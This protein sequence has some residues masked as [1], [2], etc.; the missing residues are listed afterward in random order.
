MF[1]PNI[2]NTL[3]K[4]SY[5]TRSSSR[6]FCEKLCSLDASLKNEKDI[7]GVIT[8]Q[9]WFFSAWKQDPTIKSMLCMLSGTDNSDD[10]NG[11]FVDGIEELFAN[12]TDFG[13]Y[14]ECLKSADCPIHFNFLPLSSDE[15]PVSDDLY[16]KMNARGK[17]LSSFENFKA[18]LIKWIYKDENKN[19]FGENESERNKTRAEYASLIDNQWTDIFWEAGEEKGNV[20]E[21]YFAFI[22]RFLLNSI[23]IHN[24]FTP[25]FL[26]NG[27]TKTDSNGKEYLVKPEL[28]DYFYGT[29]YEGDTKGNDDRRIAYK[30]FDFYEKALGYGNSDV[31]K[32]LKKVFQLMPERS[33]MAS[34]FPARIDK[35]GKFFIPTYSGKDIEDF[36]HVKIKETTSITLQQRVV[37]EAIC[38]YMIEADKFEETSFRRWMRVVW[39]I[40]E[41]TNESSSI[42]DF[43]TILKLINQLSKGCLDIYK[44][45]QEPEYINSSNP[46]VREEAVKAKQILQKEKEND[47]VGPDETEIIEAENY[48]F[49]NGAIRFLFTSGDGTVC[50][51]DFQTK[52]ERA[53]Q[54]FNDKGLGEARWPET[55]KILLSYCLDWENQLKRKFLFGDSSSNWIPILKSKTFIIPIHN[56]LKHY[57][58]NNKPS[59]YY[60]DILNTLLNND[61]FWTFI[62]TSDCKDKF[63]LEWK[64]N[65][66]SLWLKNYLAS[67][68]RLRQTERDK[69]LDKLSN[70]CED[71]VLHK[72][73]YVNTTQGKYFKCSP[74]NIV[75]TYRGYKFVW[76]DSDWVDMYEGETKCWD[77]AENTEYAKYYKR[78]HTHFQIEIEHGLSFYNGETLIKELERCITE[79]KI[80]KNE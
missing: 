30:N 72:E 76:Q 12:V 70:T 43:V 2:S 25:D 17:P 79:Y 42:K 65:M 47:L 24:D 31:L 39:N 37:F 51:D 64:T 48:A 80:I 14:W 36:N 6:E 3:K 57:S 13:H 7:V 9:T 16:I 66:P 77:K 78:L 69:I 44:H 29:T 75:F 49:F 8:R 60:A 50:W 38:Q 22:N 54:L 56:L 18:D 34:L 19:A 45:L 74:S 73:D 59:G 15:L 35:K 28:F 11:D 23:V 41:N 33:S 61:E 27:I 20:D 10:K 40:A 53:K 52:Y 55:N 58:I 32:E 5:E 46:Q 62:K 1:Q 4:F 67:S 21:I 68:V 63:M 71:L 26:Q